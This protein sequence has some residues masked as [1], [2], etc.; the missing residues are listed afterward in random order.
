MEGPCPLLWSTPC[1]G[2]SYGAVDPWEIRCRR[3][4][5]VM[6]YV[7]ALLIRSLRTLA[8]VRASSSDVHSGLAVRVWPCLNEVLAPGNRACQSGLPIDVAS[9][10]SP[11]STSRGS[12]PDP[13]G[14]EFTDHQRTCSDDLASRT[15]DTLRVVATSLTSR[16]RVGPE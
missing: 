5:R 8:P 10:T 15:S 6:P 11:N 4:P 13:C 7:V 3:T 2:P 16:C 12:S 1:T 9:L 14:R